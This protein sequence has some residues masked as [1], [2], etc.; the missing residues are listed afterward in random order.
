MMS[1]ISGETL[2]IWNINFVTKTIN[3]SRSL[4]QEEGMSQPDSLQNS[5]NSN[6]H[7][8]MEEYE[9]DDYK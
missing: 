9:D 5:P 2:S 4:R 7:Q 3:V 8:S 1:N 6:K